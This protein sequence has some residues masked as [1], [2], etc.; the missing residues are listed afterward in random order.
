MG[1]GLTY[2]IRLVN[3][4]G[5]TVT[6]DIYDTDY[7]DS[8]L[9]DVVR[10]LEQGGI[11][12][13][14]VDNDE[15]KFTP[16]RAKQVEL[17]FLST[18]N[19]NLS[20]FITDSPDSRFKVKVYTPSETLFYGFVVLND[21][22]QEF[23][24]NFTHRVVT[25]KAVDGL[26][27]LKDLPLTDTDGKNPKGY[28]NIITYISWCLKKTGFSL[29][30]NVMNNLRL[31][32]T[33]ETPGYAQASLHAKTFEEEIGSS[34]NCYDVLTS[35]LG[36]EC[37]L[38]QWKGEWWIRR[39]D[40]YDA[41]ANYYDRYDENGG[42]IESVENVM[43]LKEVRYKG[44][45]ELVAPPA[46]VSAERPHS[47]AKE[48][49]GYQLPAELIDNIDFS[50]GDK[51]TGPNA[52]TDGYYN[53]YNVEDWTTARESGSPTVTPYIK[54]IFNSLDYEKER[55]VV[56]PEGSG[57][58][59]LLV[60]SEIPVHA[61]D[62]ISF[63]LNWRLTTDL[64]GATLTTNIA[65]V[66]LYAEDGT[67]WNVS[68]LGFSDSSPG[69]WVQSNATFS[70]NSRV[71]QGVH[72]SDI[73][74]YTDWQ[75]ETLDTLS[76][77][78]DGVIIIHLI[79]HTASGNKETHFQD[80]RLDYYAYINGS[81]RKYSGQYSRVFRSGDYKAKQDN[82]VYVSDSPKKLFKGAIFDFNFLTGKYFLAGLWYNAAI[83]FIRAAGGTLTEYNHPLGYMQAFSVWNQY[84]RSMRLFDASLAGLDSDT[85]LP[86]LM[87]T[88]HLRDNSA[89]T[90]KKR[91]MLLHYEMDLY[92]CLWS[93]FFA[94]VYDDNKGKEY[95][96]TFEFKYIS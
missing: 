53:T 71:M 72:N 47:E 3:I 2:R 64:S 76:I 62:K 1:L 56:I 48:T 6:G 93:G 14:V 32:T 35:I 87:H 66:R 26:G 12:L 60:S 37:F 43:Y 7:I 33:P 30:I 77:P 78:R 16:I 80:L 31:V 70:L 90:Y 73:T 18:N 38:T 57:A 41:N 85:E 74:D 61:K 92:T 49:F 59:H 27:L 75:S 69:E 11:R 58:A 55:Y 63:S 10:T 83:P 79:E 8:P 13:S 39:V 84:R 22:S 5:T 24:D 20:T 96:D 36:Q 45:I 29:P 51:L 81:Y 17:D 95:G 50:R 34:V 19:F 21:I 23:R 91:F 15:D 52:I 46:L 86:D 25:I 4:E 67:F 88:Y 82:E 9:D 44:T 42:F 40:E 54:K 65:Y 89:H 28:H 94:E 68:N